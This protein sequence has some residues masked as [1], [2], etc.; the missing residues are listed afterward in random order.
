MELHELVA[1]Q[2]N[3]LMG[4]KMN[5]PHIKNPELKELYMNAIQGLEQNLKELLNYFPLA[6]VTGMRAMPDDD[7]TAFYAAHL[8]IF[9]KT[10]VRNYAIAITETATP[11]LR[12]LL[13]KQLN[14]T[15]KLHGDAYQFMYTRGLYPSYDLN[16]LLKNDQKNAN[17][18]IKL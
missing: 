4:F 12:Q 3:Y 11:N 9:A 14:Q 13:Q 6:P 7:A 5:A 1:F 10:A 2:T 18:A 8:L 17:S 15:I 16:L